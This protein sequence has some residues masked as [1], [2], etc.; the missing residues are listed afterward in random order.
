MRYYCPPPPH[1]LRLLRLIVTSAGV[2]CGAWFGALYGFRGVPLSHYEALE[3]R[4]RAETAADRL[5]ALA[6]NR[7]AETT[8]QQDHEQH[9]TG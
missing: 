3:Y 8:P 4:E 7:D 1:Q 2:I 9:I 5:L 6:Q